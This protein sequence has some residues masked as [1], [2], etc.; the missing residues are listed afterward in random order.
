MNP[1]IKE[2]WITALRSGE[3]E[4]GTATLRGIDG[5]YCCLGVLCELAV[6]DGVV[7]RATKDTYGHLYRSTAD[8]A[9]C[10][11]SYL[12]LA[13]QQWAGLNSTSPRVTGVAYYDGEID[14]A[15]LNDSGSFSF[16][17]IA[18]IIEKKL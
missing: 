1:D 7:G 10:Q 18:D 11:K 12:P 14:L 17:A 4:Q 3:Y 15:S 5:K 2:R 8:L 9:D 6:A 13:V 16:H